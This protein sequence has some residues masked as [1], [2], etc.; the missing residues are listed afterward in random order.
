MQK[1]YIHALKLLIGNGVN[2]KFD[3]LNFYARC[4]KDFLREHSST[5]L[6]SS[7]F[8]SISTRVSTTPVLSLEY[9]PYYF[10]RP[11]FHIGTGHKHALF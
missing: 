9:C 3:M 4:L 10:C 8:S 5:T 2:L 7:S 1:A 11:T 6:I